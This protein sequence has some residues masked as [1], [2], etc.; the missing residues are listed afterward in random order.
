MWRNLL[1]SLC[2]L[3]LCGVAFGQEQMPTPAQATQPPK[4]VRLNKGDTRLVWVKRFNPAYPPALRADRVQ[5]SVVLRTVFDTTG[6]FKEL[7]LVSGDG[8]LALVAAKA[9][10]QWKC[11]PY[12]VDGQAVEIETDITFTFTLGS[13]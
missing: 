4:R 1:M 9:V 12:E 3:Y 13:H 7:Q 11:K 5:G 10:R 2:A 6:D 8:R